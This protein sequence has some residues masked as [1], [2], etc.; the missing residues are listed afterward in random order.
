METYDSA[1]LAN[2][3][4]EQGRGIVGALIVSVESLFTMEMW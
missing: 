1:M 3:A 4:R 2:A